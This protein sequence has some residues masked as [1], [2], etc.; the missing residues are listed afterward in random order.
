MELIK[1]IAEHPGCNI[2]DKNYWE[3]T[4]LHVASERGREQTITYLLSL[5]ANAWIKN[6]KKVLPIDVAKNA[7]T[8]KLFEDWAM[9][10][11]QPAQP[12]PAPQAAKTTTAPSAES[13]SDSLVA[14]AAEQQQ[15]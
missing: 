13:A 15:Q 2:N 9:K 11:P 14:P 1:T 8:K 12:E 6:E 5:G 7:A 10:N 4:A 3:D